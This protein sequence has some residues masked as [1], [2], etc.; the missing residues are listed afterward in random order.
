MP[1]MHVCLK[2]RLKS[3]RVVR[4]RELNKS[5]PRH[6]HVSNVNTCL[7]TDKNVVHCLTKINLCFLLVKL[8][9]KITYFD[10]MSF[11]CCLSHFIYQCY[12]VCSHPPTFFVITFRIN[13][14]QKYILMSVR[15]YL[16]WSFVIY[17]QHV[18]MIC[19]NGIMFQNKSTLLG[20]QCDTRHV[21]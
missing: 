21:S 18:R 1:G 19:W 11:K 2:N 17:T 8:S 7:C 13:I 3:S 9:W 12:F 4:G 15:Y 10:I 5:T 6:C 14:Q 16:T 20:N